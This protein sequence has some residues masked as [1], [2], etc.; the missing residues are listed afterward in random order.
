[1]DVK[2]ENKDIA[3]KPNGD[4]VYISSMDET[5]QRVKIACSIN[6]G[7][8]IYDRNIGFDTI[9]TDDEVDKDKLE[10]IFCEAVIGIPDTV[11][12]VID[13]KKSGNRITATLKIQQ[14]DNTAETEVTVNG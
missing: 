4:T 10:M 13:A 6:K 11:V 1:M 3:L 8:F 14:G 5:V 2:I 12:Q 9:S 7:S